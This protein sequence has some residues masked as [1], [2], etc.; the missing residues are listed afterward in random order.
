VNK[1]A[2]RFKNTRVFCKDLYPGTGFYSIHVTNG[3][4]AGMIFFKR[5]THSNKKINTGCVIMLNAP[6]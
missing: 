1:F 3:D 2:Q 4:N 6:V 5:K